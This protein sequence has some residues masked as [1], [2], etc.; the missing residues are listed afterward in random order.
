MGS[1]VEFRPSMAESIEMRRT[2]SFT[3]AA[4]L[5]VEE[6]KRIAQITSG[7]YQWDPFYPEE[8]TIFYPRDGIA[9]AFSQTAG[10]SILLPERESGF[11]QDRRDHVKQNEYH[12]S[13]VVAFDVNGAVHIV[14]PQ[15]TENIE[16]GF[17][18]ITIQ[19]GINTKQIT[20]H[21]VQDIQTVE[22]SVLSQA[23]W[24]AYEQMMG[25]VA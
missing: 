3:S 6:Q 1:V 8:N 21:Q 4:E 7:S 10:F 12:P 19:A 15:S 20:F 17:S 5:S 13:A 9:V 22:R 24:V 2:P 25:S 18:G 23:A 16:Y 14:W 11:N